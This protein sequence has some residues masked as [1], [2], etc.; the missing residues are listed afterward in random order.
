MDKKVLIIINPRSGTM[1]ANRYMTDIVD[2]F[3]NEGY[4]PTVLTTTKSG[5]GTEYALKYAKDYNLVVCIGGD[6]T[7]NEV[8]AGIVDSCA[9]TP[10]GYIP[11]GSTNDFANSLG[12][13]K[14]ILTSAAD[15]LNGGAMKSIDLG[16]FNGRVFSYVASF[17]AFTATSYNTP[18]SVK[19]ALGHLAYILSG[20]KELANLEKIHMKVEADGDIYEGDYLFGAISNSTSIAGLLSLKEEHVDLN[21]G[22]FEMLLIKAPTNI[23]ELND[24]ISALALQNYY[25]S[26]AITFVNAKHFDI[27]TDKN[28]SWT[29]DGEYQKGDEN[30]HIENIKSAI[31]TIV[32]KDGARI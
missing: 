8:A 22:L 7:F 3:V 19:N 6:G 1:R 2:L 21:D 11:S 4:M 25:N 12:L 10:I 9:G 32:I 14:D 30:I 29:L 24:L 5:D 27:T 18:Q 26:N 20:V 15:I 23:F 31:R 17:G 13:S 16:R 28:L